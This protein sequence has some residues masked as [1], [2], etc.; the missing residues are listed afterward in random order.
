MSSI[1]YND[2]NP[3]SD[4]TPTYLRDL[5]NFILTFFYDKDIPVHYV[6]GTTYRPNYFPNQDLWSDVPLET[7]TVKKFRYVIPAS[8]VDRLSDLRFFNNM[9]IQVLPEG[10]NAV[11]GISRSYA[12]SERAFSITIEYFLGVPRNI[13]RTKLCQCPLK[14]KCILKDFEELRLE[15][16]MKIREKENERD[17]RNGRFSY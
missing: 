11:F 17:A 4:D 2:Y 9:R 6:E 1:S 8:R 15:C 14:L 3:D 7:R 16:F 13:L 5:S 10:T 12:T